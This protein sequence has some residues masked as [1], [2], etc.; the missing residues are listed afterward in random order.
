MGRE[1]Q[2]QSEEEFQESELDQSTPERQTIDDLV[3]DGMEDEANVTPEPVLAP[4]E[5]AMRTEESNRGI[6]G[7][8]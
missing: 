5:Q 1:R 4:E 7:G 3:P 6:E 8:A 2:A